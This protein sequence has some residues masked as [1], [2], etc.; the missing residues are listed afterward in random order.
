MTARMLDAQLKSPLTLS[1]RDLPRRVCAEMATSMARTH[2][3]SQLGPPYAL[4]K[5]IQCVPKGHPP[6]GVR[7]GRKWTPLTKQASGLSGA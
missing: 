5:S 1:F 3:T 6:F 4:R 2:S 7:L